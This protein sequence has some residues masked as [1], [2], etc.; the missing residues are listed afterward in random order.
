MSGNS[1]EVDVPDRLDGLSL[2]FVVVWG[3][4]WIRKERSF[5]LID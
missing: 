5:G 2:L 3:C 4:R 1:I